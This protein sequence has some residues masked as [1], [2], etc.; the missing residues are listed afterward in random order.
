M[1]VIADSTPFWRMMPTLAAKPLG[2]AC[3]SSEHWASCTKRHRRELLDQR[4]ALIQL[5]RRP[6]SLSIPR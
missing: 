4:A 3:H 1:I 2:A 5:Q 6:A